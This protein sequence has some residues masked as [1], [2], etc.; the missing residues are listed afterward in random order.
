MKRVRL[1]EKF[2]QFDDQWSPRIVAALNGQHVKLAKI[3][4]AFVWHCHPDADELFL[5]VRGAMEMHLRDGVVHL[6]A[7][8]L[9]VVPR[10]TEHRPVA[11]REAEILLV[12]PAGTVNTGTAGGDRTV[13]DPAW[14]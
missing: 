14:I 8:D 7:G 11:E 12:E 6:E 9:F 2:A 13:N 5:V 3:E 10:G 4:G 1:S